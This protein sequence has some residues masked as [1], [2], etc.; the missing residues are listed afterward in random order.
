[1]LRVVDINLETGCAFSCYSC[2]FYTNK[3][4]EYKKHIDS[5]RHKINITKPEYAERN[6]ALLQ[7]HIFQFI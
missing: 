6:I 4:D 3:Y 5:D 7:H 2:S 1:M